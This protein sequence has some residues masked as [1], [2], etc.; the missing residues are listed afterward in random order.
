MV[1]APITAAGVVL[2]DGDKVLLVRRARPPRAGEWSLPGGKQIAGERIEEAALR[3]LR[4]ET[5]LEA[6]LLG[7]V[8]VVDAMFG[9]AGA[10]THHY[11]LVDFAARPT[12]G[13]L[14]AASDAAEAAWH[15][16]LGLA[17]PW[18]LERDL[19]GDRGSAKNVPG[20]LRRPSRHNSVQAGGQGRPIGRG[21]MRALI[22]ALLFVAGPL[23]AAAQTSTP[24]A[25]SSQSYR[26]QLMRLSEILGGL[27]S[28]RTHC[29]SAGDSHWRD[30]MMELIRL[31]R[32]SV[33]ERNAMIERFNAGYAA[34]NSRFSTC[35]DAARAYAQT[36][37]REGEGISRSLAQ[38]V[39][40]ATSH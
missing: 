13:R 21:A 38:A 30:R 15:P 19:A 39:D 29:E 26:G 24:P 5:G 27:H 31:E 23:A 20:V 7:L 18:P 6:E 2:L 11:L 35:S 12:G 16:G 32:P 10:L 9:D 14:A 37:A 25:D 28:V 17:R 40:E 33:D 4:E 1:P 34:T 22:F 36:L 8:A 3:E